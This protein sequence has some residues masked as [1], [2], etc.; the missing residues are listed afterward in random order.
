MK[1]I[2]V[3]VLIAAVSVMTGYLARFVW[4]RILLPLSRR[5]RTTL[6]QI[7]IERSAAPL[8]RLIAAGGLL[9]AVRRLLLLP[10]LAG[11]AGLRGCAEL[12]YVLVVVSVS[13]L[14]AAVLHGLSEWYVQEAEARAKAA[15]DTDLVA[16]FSRVGNIAIF[17][18]AATVIL[19]HFNVNITGFLATAGVASLAVALAAQE[20]LANT[21]SGIALILDRPF[22]V[23]DWVVLEDGEAGIVQEV[24]LRSTRL[25]SFDNTLIIVPNAQMARSKIVNRSYPDLRIKV[26]REIGVAYGTDIKQAK[27]ILLEIISAHPGV[28]KDPAPAIF[29]TEFGDSALKLLCIYWVGDLREQ[30]VINDELNMRI[31]ERFETEGIV[32]PFPQREVHLRRL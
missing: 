29:F 7:L 3:S 10:E 11:L 25:L 31:K 1:E 13:L 15:F 30:F 9:F 19:S 28:L 12:V 20:T 18:V 4:M 8:C 22:R 16:L 6:D 2:L 17:F 21:F 24:G 27:R 26:R 23:N 14:A 5:T 32:I